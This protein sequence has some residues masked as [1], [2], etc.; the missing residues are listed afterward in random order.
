MHDISHIIW[1]DIFSD[2]YTRSCF[3]SDNYMI[4][5]KFRDINLIFGINICYSLN[6]QIKFHYLEKAQNLNFYI[7]GNH[8]NLNFDIHYMLDDIFD[9][10][11][12]VLL[13]QNIQFCMCRMNIIL[14]NLIERNFFLDDMLNIHFLYFRN[15][16]DKFYGIKYN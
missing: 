11:V 14:S 10:Y 16:F 13:N 6:F 4:L 8:K 2:N 9:I 3:S 7:L 1:L 5:G 15:M 12:N